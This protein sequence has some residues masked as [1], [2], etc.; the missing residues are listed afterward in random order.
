MKLIIL[1]GIIQNSLKIVPLIIV[2]ISLNSCDSKVENYKNNEMMDY[3]LILETA[4]DSL[5]QNV[6]SLNYMRILQRKREYI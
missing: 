6:D 1:K 5:N 4:V 2:L 3:I